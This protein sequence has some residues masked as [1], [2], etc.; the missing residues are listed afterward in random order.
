MGAA[1]YLCKEVTGVWAGFGLP[2]IHFTYMAMALFAATVALLAVFS[3]TSV[4]APAPAEAV[5]RRSDLTEGI[6][7]RSWMADYRLQASVLFVL[8]IAVVAAFW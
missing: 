5:F 2:H 8:M 4:P 1:L 7:G 3:I 6:T